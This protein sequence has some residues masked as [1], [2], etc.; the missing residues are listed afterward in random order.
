MEISDIA[1]KIFTGAKGM[2]TQEQAQAVAGQMLED[3]HGGISPEDIR[4]VTV[5]HSEGRMDIQLHID[6]DTLPTVIT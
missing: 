1:D 5:T 3:T 6:F 4:D 2:L